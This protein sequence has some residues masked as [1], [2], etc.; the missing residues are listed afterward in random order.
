MY[1]KSATK[2]EPVSLIVTGRRANL[3]DELCADLKSFPH[4]KHAVPLAV[5]VSDKE[6]MFAA[7]EG[8]PEEVKN[9]DVLVN[10]AGLALGTAPIHEGSMDDWEMMVDVNCKGLLYATKAVLPGMVERGDGHIINIGR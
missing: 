6:K 2:D 3:L 1:A 7:I 8:L 5:D 4:V 9:I 10:N